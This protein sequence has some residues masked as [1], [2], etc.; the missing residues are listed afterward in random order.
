MRHQLAGEVVSRADPLSLGGTNAARA[1]EAT[2]AA[3]PHGG[4]LSLVTSAAA[5]ELLGEKWR[6]LQKEAAPHQVF[7]SFEWCASWARSYAKPEYGIEP[8]VVTGYEDRKL[9]FVWPLMKVRAGPLTVLRWLSD[10]FGQYGDIVIARK[11]DARAWM[12][13]AMDLLTR[14]KGIDVIRL[15]HVRNDAAAF[16]FLNDRFRESGDTDTAPFLDLTAYPDEKAYEQRYT[17]E[18]R[19]RR[20]KIRKALEHFGPVQFEL[21]EPGPAMD[22]S[23]A[24]AIA[25]KRSWLKERGLYSKPLICPLLDGFLRELSQI[26]GDGARLVASRLTAGARTIS[27]EIGM[28]FASTHFGFITAH[29]TSLTDASPARLHMDLSQRQAIKDG[30]R[31]FDLMVP[32]DPHKESW[33]NGQMAVR[34]FYVPLSLAG[35]TYAF[36]YLRLLRPVM[37]WLYVAAPRPIRSYFTSLP[38]I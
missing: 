25:S 19:R 17:K 21:L 28:R 2:I 3:V 18:Q 15:R 36:A 37:Q 10:P 6:E 14:L 30:M 35:S 16:G 9:V 12:A 27:W 23:I 1:A 24:E 5:L 31:R 26:K 38:F 4:H 32:G 8:C 13:G 34:E 7:Q 22:K 33:S 11:A 20:K 29:D